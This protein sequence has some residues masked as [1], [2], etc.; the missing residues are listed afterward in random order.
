MCRG[1]IWAGDGH[2]L[3]KA[4]KIPG[5]KHSNQ[6]GKLIAVL[7]ALQSVNPLSPL[8]I[9]TDSKYDI[10]WIRIDNTTLF[11][12]TAYHL[13]RADQLALTRA[14]CHE[15]DHINTYKLAYTEIMNKSNSTY[16]RV[17]I[18]L[19]DITRFA[20]ELVSTNLET[21]E[22][23]W[24]GCR[25]KDLSKNTQMFIYKA[26]NNAYCIGEYW[27]NVPGYEHQA[28]CSQ[29]PGE[30]ESLEHIIIQCKNPV[31]RTIWQLAK[32]TWPM[33]HGPW[34]E[35]HISLVLGCGTISL[36]NKTQSRNTNVK[37]DTLLKKGASCLLRILISESAYLIW[38][39]RCER[40]I[41]EST[42]NEDAVRQRWANTIDKRLQLDRVLASKI[43]RDSK[44]E[45][46]VRN[47]WSKVL[48]NQIQHSPNNW[49]TNLE[50]LVGIKL[51]RPSQTV[52]TR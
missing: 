5:N 16:K 17:T 1:G 22:T 10:G 39:I 19:L 25:N 20:V 36:P 7:I 8:K 24:R 6:I 28:K 14:R 23:I 50:V 52:E 30:I 26:L 40:V 11:K 21:D 31:R 51:L 48:H 44:T 4:I 33:K 12:A 37:K 27:E 15:P 47:M 45:L 34:P 2:Q 29:C 3:N 13:R 49:V 35:Q 46:K 41:H 43:R 9:I 32:D 38:T 18:S 42:H